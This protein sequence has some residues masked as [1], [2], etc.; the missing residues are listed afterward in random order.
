MACSPNF[1][2]AAMPPDPFTNP[3]AVEQLGVYTE[4]GEDVGDEVAPGGRVAGSE[5][6]IQQLQRHQ[7]L[8][9]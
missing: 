9:S 2:S 3:V 7:L 6:A 4:P 1:W 5:L 8:P